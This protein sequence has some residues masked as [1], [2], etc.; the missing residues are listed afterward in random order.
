VTESAFVAVGKASDLAPGRMKW[1]AVE[2]ERVLLVNVA[3]V[4]YALSD[5]CG[6]QRAPLSRGRLEGHV[7]ECPVHFAR[8]DV[9]TGR[10]LSGPV[11]EDV[12]IHEVR[13]DGDTVYVRQSRIRPPARGGDPP[14]GHSR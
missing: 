10:L 8:F 11:A 5:A 12:L 9:R 7:V 3:G 6:H 14:P 1:V 4:F 2:R 13:I